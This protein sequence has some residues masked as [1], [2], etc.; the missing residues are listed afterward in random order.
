LSSHTGHA[1]AAIVY[2]RRGLAITRPH[3]AV[4]ARIFMLYAAPAAI[5]AALAVGSAG[6]QPALWEQA[7]MLVLPYLTAI[8]GTVVVM[9]AVGNQARGRRVGVLRA[10]LMALP[11]VPRYLWTNV[12]TT[13]IFW[14]PVGLLLLARA[15]Q[16]KTIALSGG[17]QVAVTV[18]W[19]FV[20]AVVALVLHTRTLLAPFLAIHGDL[21]G[22]LAVLEAWRASGR[23]F[24][25][26]LSTLIAAGGPVVVPLLGLSLV[27]ILTL[28]GLALVVFFAALGDLVWVAIQAT[29][30]V[31]IPA[32]YALYGDLWK[33]ES[34]RRRRDGEPPV[35]T[36]ARVLL[37]LTR[38]LPNPGRLSDRWEAR[39]VE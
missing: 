9:V 12:H 30:P 13:V 10:S 20:I 7:A 28:P 16:E 34:A 35:P 15:W 36:V 22:T 1:R 32:L 37:A 4:Q 26:C 31:L 19:W 24:G 29:R 18:L 14:I 8:L 38:P 23:H 21:P 33:A 11:W 6:R 25:V 39:L 2:L 3:W 27:L 5:A 17:L